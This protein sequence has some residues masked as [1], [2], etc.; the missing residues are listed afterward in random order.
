MAEDVVV[1][2][3]GHKGKGVFAA[4]D[5]RKGELIM[6]FEGRVV[7]RD[8]LSSLTPWELEHLGE[9]TADTFQ[10][11]PSPRCYLN[12]GCAPTAVSTSNAVYA[13]QD[14]AA[15]QEITIDYRL[16][17]HDDGGVWK[18][19]CRCEAYDAPHV[20]VGDFFS[21][22]D[23]TQELYVPWAPSFI[24]TEYSRRRGMPAKH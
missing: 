17:A 3:A 9:L 22:P 16:N 20:V 6:P 2:D 4:R 14:I 12:H 10:V 19:T 13:W 24:Q 7:H 23:D 11:L 1:G 21:L 5:F 15:G 8:E 18:V